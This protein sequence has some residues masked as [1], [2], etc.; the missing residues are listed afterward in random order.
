[1]LTN[2]IPIH[3]LPWAGPLVIGKIALL[4]SSVIYCTAYYVN[5][6]VCFKHGYPIVSTRYYKS[7]TEDF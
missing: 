3:Y 1:M 6:N 4:S 2:I 7:P 5:C